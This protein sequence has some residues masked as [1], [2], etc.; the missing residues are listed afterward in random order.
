MQAQRSGPLF[1][2]AAA[3]RVAELTEA[4]R[5]P[6]RFSASLRVEYSVDERPNISFTSN[7]SRDGMSL[8]SAPVLPAEP[9]TRFSI[10]LDD[11]GEPLVINGRA[12]EDPNGS[13]RVLF[14][15]NQPEAM[16]RL[17]AYIAH[18]VLPKLEKACDSRRPDGDKLVSLGGFYLEMG[19]TEEAWALWRKGVEAGLSQVGPYEMLALALLERAVGEGLEAGDTLEELDGIIELGWAVEESERLAEISEV[20]A[21]LAEAINNEYE[22]LE[23]EEQER[24]VEARVQER[25]ESALAE[26]RAALEATHAAAKKELERELHQVRGELG[27]E[28]AQ[29]EARLAQAATQAQALE[30]RA[31]QAEQQAQEA[32]AELEAEKVQAY[33]RFEQERERHHQE[34]QQWERIEAERVEL[35]EELAVARRELHQAQ[36]SL[37]DL[38]GSLAAQKEALEDARADFEAQTANVRGQLGELERELQQCLEERDAWRQSAEARAQ[39]AQERNC[40]LRAE[41]SAIVNTGTADYLVSAVRDIR[42]APR[43]PNPTQ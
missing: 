10:K 16:A 30:S 31:Q 34:R 35:A 2:A 26:T 33:E 19:R 21:E 36:I 9:L 8:R 27:R 3:A 41:M 29:W 20:A 18:Q 1:N 7:L 12:G 32:R 39:Q 43:E 6:Q 37:D 15:P 17:D 25:V 24:Q 28:R 22:R 11:G 4:M 23:R 42:R 38:R 14:A 40:V 13:P 5:R